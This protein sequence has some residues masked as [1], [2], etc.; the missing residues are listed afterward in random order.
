MKIG[1]A[2][3]LI[4]PREPLS[5]GGYFNRRP[6]SGRLGDLKVRAL[7]L[8]EAEVDYC[9]LVYD[10]LEVG[11][12]IGAAVAGRLADNGLSAARLFQVATHTHT[13]PYVGPSREGWNSPAYEERLIG[14]AFAC[15]RAARENRQPLAGAR[16][17]VVDGPPL[18]FNRRFWMRDGRVVTNP[19]KLNPAIDRPEGA[20]DR[21]IGLLLLEPGDGP[22]V[23]L[24]NIVNHGDTTGG[25]R[26]SPDWPGHLAAALPG[27]LGREVKVITLVGTAGNI[28]HF[29]IS[30]ARGQQGPEE[31]R[32]IGFAYARA[33]AG[34][35]DRA[36]PCPVTPLA[37]GRRPVPVAPRPLPARHLERFRRE[38]VVPVEEGRDFTSEDLA[39]GDAGAR[40]LLAR[41]YLGKL[42]RGERADVTV[43]ALRLGEAVLVFLPGEPFVETGLAVRDSSPARL[44]MVAE[45]SAGGLGS[46]D[47]I[48]NPENFGRGGYETHP[49][50]APYGQDLALVL[51][52]E[53]GALLASLF[54]KAAPGA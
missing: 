6:W 39:R 30:S 52:R 9:L 2:E 23:L 4:N 40:S 5:L 32:R 35:L 46:G 47:Y 7:W 14:Q 16:A 36:V 22:A 41:E 31:A 29:D 27:L 53:A 50:S 51:R 25:D 24:A 54:D 49:R 19:G 34:A 8:A 38:A 26:F 43:S 3:A 33:A 21:S 11:D 15:A 20:E 44:T 45:L 18:S 48:P 1:Y 10:L 13:A 17:A 12:A 28:N 42:A 37:A